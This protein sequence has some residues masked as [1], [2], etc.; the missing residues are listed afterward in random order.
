[1]TRFQL[2]HA[3]LRP[4]QHGD[5]TSLA[6]H[7]NSRAVWLN[8]RDRFPHPYTLDDAK[9]WVAHQ[10]AQ[11]GPTRNWAIEIEGEVGG[12]I[13]LDMAADV[14]RK[15]VNIGYWLGERFWGRGIATEAVRV[16]TEHAFTLD[17]DRVHA[18]VYAY[19]PAS[20]RVLEKAGFEREGVLRKSIFK[21]G[22]TIDSV[23][24]ARVRA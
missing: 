21:D 20:M 16:V 9:A 19:N 3:L 24:Y 15:D 17:I 22:K 6:R 23:L 18:Q 14:H 2:E 10:L 7:A 1:M 4:W 13:G 8:L 5:E 12:G 11:E